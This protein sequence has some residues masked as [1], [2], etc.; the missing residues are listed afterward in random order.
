MTQP[1]CER[2]EPLR[3]VLLEWRALPSPGL[4]TIS[5][6]YGQ[7][8]KAPE[9]VR[10][11]AELNLQGRLAAAHFTGW[12]HSKQTPQTQASQV[13]VPAGSGG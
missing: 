3:T 10:G 6:K 2:A 12:H 5:S 1:G 4:T 9:E 13:K 8:A 7:Q 11:S